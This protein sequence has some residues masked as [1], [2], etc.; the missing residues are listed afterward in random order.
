MEAVERAADS[1]T[2]PHTR[3]MSFAGH[4]AQS[5]AGCTGTVM[6]FVP[7]VKGISHNPREFSSDE[8]C[9]HGANVLLHTVLEL[10]G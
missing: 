1:L 4:D 3:L 2:L 9:V 6:L 10:A 7:S 8:D 5:L